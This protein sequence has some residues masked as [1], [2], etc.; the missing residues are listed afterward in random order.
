MELYQKT[1]IELALKNNALRFGEFT[2]KSGRISPYFFNVGQ[3][4]SGAILKTL[5]MSYAHAIMNSTLQFDVLFGP[6][7]KGIPIVC[8][9]AMAYATLQ[10]DIPYAF[11]RKEIKDH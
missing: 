6:A 7:Y 4:N 10:E 11:D 9:T 2:L 1:F 5:G 8:A 3:L